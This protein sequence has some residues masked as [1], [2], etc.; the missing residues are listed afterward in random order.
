MTGVT[1]FAFLDRPLP[2]A[3]AH[4]GGALEAEENTL[5]AFE[6]AAG[7][8]YSHIETDVQATRDG[9]AVIFH[10]AELAR[11]T[12]RVGAIADLDWSTVSRL[13]TLGGA[14]LPRLE[15]ALAAFPTLYF[16]IEAKSDAAV[17]PMADAIRRCGAR[18]R[19]CIGSMRVRRTHRL[20]ALLGDDICWS[21]AHRDV[22]QLWLAG[23]GLPIP[24]PQYPCVQVPPHFHGVP[25]VTPRFVAA[26]HAR[27]LQVHV[28]TVNSETEM[29]RL[30]ELGVDGLMTDRPALLRT[31]LQRRG[32]FGRV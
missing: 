18:S 19:I 16:N 29:E 9:V 5:E 27:G 8:G 17:G 32:K 20:R 14:R 6:H 15:E 7:L 26:A 21:P 12:G 28:W 3:F 10:D 25:V 24:R 22:A 30:L 11:M 4:R 2:L 13:R 1:G 31:V 23:W